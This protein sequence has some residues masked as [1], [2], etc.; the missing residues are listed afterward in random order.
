VP[1]LLALVVSSL[2]WAALDMLRKKL[3]ARLP[4]VTVAAFLSVGLT[5]LFLA[6][7]LLRGNPRLES[8]YATPALASGLLSAV[9]IV[10]FC[11][12]L[13]RG[14]LS[15]G[16]PL[17]SLTP[18]FASLMGLLLIGERPTPA[19]WAGVLLVMAG[20]VA[21]QMRGATLHADRATLSMVAV[22]FLWALTSVY[23][24]QALQ[25]A[26]APVHG[27]LQCAGVGAVLMALPGARPPWSALRPTGTLMAVSVVVGAVALLLQFVALTLTLVAV[28]E[29]VKRAIGVLAAVVVGKVVFGEPITALKLGA[30]AA[31]VG[32]VA[33]LL[34]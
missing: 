28:V 7:V 4:P 18:V 3:V 27:L 12:A 14:P 8:G 1:A 26:D 21:L 9:A 23:D 17:L 20:A 6:W 13:K 16:V 22:A 33:L 24:K 29:T 31:M 15:T 30:V 10:L 34:G 2:A 25:F 5:P 32:G 11:D 19:Q